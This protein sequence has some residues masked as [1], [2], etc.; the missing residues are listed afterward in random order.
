MILKVRDGKQVD[1]VGSGFLC[2]SKGYVLTCAHLFSLGEKIAISAS[3][4]INNWNSIT[5]TQVQAINAQI[6][7]YN[8]LNDVALLKLDGLVQV[9]VPRGV[10][11]SADSSI[12]GS[13]VVYF[14]YPFGDT[15][16]HVLKM[17]ASIISSKAMS[18]N[19]TKR[20]QLDSMVHNG[21][22]GGPL[23]DVGSEKI[24]GIISG[25]QSPTGAS[26]G[27]VMIGNYA[28]G[29]ESSVAYATA[30]EYGIALM[31]QEGLDA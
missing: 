15:G 6:V 23:Y 27:G 7:Q 25:K 4:P 2:H 29:Q 12:V 24:V 16:L 10:F 13:S 30:I 9:N 14:G 20:L 18:E 5:K 21:T 28:L 1:F 26:Q 11:G 19:G 31:K 17:S 3:D 22:G 8:S